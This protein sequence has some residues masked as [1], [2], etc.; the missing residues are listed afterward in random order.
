LHSQ[1]FGTYGRTNVRTAN[2]QVQRYM[3]PLCGGIKIYWKLCLQKKASTKQNYYNIY[4]PKKKN[5]K[6]NAKK[7][8]EKCVYRRKNQ[9]TCVYQ[10]KIFS[11][12]CFYQIKKSTKNVNQR[13]NPHKMCLPK[14]QA[15]II[16][17]QAIHKSITG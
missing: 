16:V 11:E 6:S 9:Q 7:S 17:L 14:K 5:Q 2:G 8:T 3:L 10:R 13:K 15:I 12:N 1:D 4:L